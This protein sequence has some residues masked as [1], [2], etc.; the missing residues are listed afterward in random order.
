[1]TYLA[2]ERFVVSDKTVLLMSVADKYVYDS[3]YVTHGSVEG[4]VK[5]DGFR[6]SAG[7]VAEQ[8]IPCLLYTSR[9]V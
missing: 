6:L 3:S 1:M 9:C 5:S 8:M 2:V 7:L 4:C